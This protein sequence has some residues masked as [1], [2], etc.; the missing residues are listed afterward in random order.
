MREKQGKSPGWSFTKGDKA[1]GKR[2]GGI[3][4]LHILRGVSCQVHASRLTPGLILKYTF[5]L[6]VG[7]ALLRFPGWCDYQCWHLSSVQASQ[8]EAKSFGC[9]TPSWRSELHF[10]SL[11]LWL[12][13]QLLLLWCGETSESGQSSGDLKNLVSYSSRH[14]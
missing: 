13:L 8:A 7:G 4:V 12:S 3:W 11:G 1:V 9:G 14:L 6:P 2:C 10:C 5:D